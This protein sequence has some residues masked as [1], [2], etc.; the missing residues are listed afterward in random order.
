M[1]H[2]ETFPIFFFCMLHCYVQNMCT[3]HVERGQP[4]RCTGVRSLILLQV[5]PKTLAPRAQA[6]TELH[7]CA[8]VRP[9]PS[10]GRKHLLRFLLSPLIW[11]VHIVYHE[12]RRIFGCG[13]YA[14]LCQPTESW[15]IGISLSPFPNYIPRKERDCCSSVSPLL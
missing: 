3:A 14:W 15:K 8:C 5:A 6:A 1:L 7:S 13:L 10:A 12:S 11:R 4:L 2:C 9:A